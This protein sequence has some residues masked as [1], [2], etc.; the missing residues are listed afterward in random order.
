MYNHT[1]IR[2]SRYIAQVNWFCNESDK[3][4]GFSVVDGFLA[5]GCAVMG[6]FSDSVLCHEVDYFYMGLNVRL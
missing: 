4:K 3:S 1:V 2:K 5:T 6:K